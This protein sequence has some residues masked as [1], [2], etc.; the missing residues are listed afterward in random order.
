ML[1]HDLRARRMGGGGQPEA[2]RIPRLVPRGRGGEQGR[3]QARI[4]AQALRA[5]G[6]EDLRRLRLVVG[7]V[8]GGARQGRTCCH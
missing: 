3:L 7:V 5:S 8:A 2:G 1:A 4:A 6:A